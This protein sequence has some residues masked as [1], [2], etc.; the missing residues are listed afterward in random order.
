M[1]YHNIHVAYNGWSGSYWHDTNSGVPWPAFFIPLFLSAFT[2][3]ILL[4]L[5]YYCILYRAPYNQLQ[6]SITVSN[7]TCTYN[8]DHVTYS[9]PLYEVVI[10]HYCTWCT[11]Y[12]G[13][14]AS[15]YFCSSCSILTVVCYQSV[16]GD[17]RHEV[18]MYM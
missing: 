18:H 7:I 16:K 2:S 12:S 3:L 13:H 15:L 6:E 4:S 17:E 14:F 11:I 10:G 9:Q 8:I 5:T 1:L